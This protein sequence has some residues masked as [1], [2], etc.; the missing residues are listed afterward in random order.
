[1]NRGFA[2]CSDSAAQPPQPPSFSA[3]PPPEPRPTHD[4][5]PGSG[6]RPLRPPPPPPPPRRPRRR[7]VAV[8]D[9]RPDAHRA[10]VHDR[11]RLPGGGDRV[12]EGAPAAGLLRERRSRVQRRRRGRVRGRR[13][14]GADGRR[15]GAAERAAE[16]RHVGRLR[17][18]VGARPGA[19]GGHQQ[20]LRRRDGPQPGKCPI[21]LL[22][23]PPAHRRRPNRQQ[24]KS[25]G[26]SGGR[27]ATSWS[28]STTSSSRTWPR[29]PWP[30]RWV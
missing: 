9:V 2:G 15:G 5:P 12:R 7:A 4:A 6:R 10:A 14:G 26:T 23:P 13:S 3:S 17:G 1:M 20:R 30:R 24:Q 21:V 29:T 16:F 11:R 8:D 18:L 27:V 25:S 22:P 28:W 19:R